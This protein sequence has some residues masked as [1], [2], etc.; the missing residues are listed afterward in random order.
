MTRYFLT[1]VNELLAAWSDR[2]HDHNT[3]PGKMTAGELGH[4]NTEGKPEARAHTFSRYNPLF[5]QSLEPGIASL[6]IALINCFD[7]VTYSSCQGHTD[8]DGKRIADLRHVGIIPRN[9]QEKRTL[10]CELT[11]LLTQVHAGWA[12]KTKLDLVVTQIES[13]SKSFECLDIVFDGN[14]DDPNAYFSESEALSN[15]MIAILWPDL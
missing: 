9:D 1:N 10:T 6:V 13:D 5:R 12:G 2:F 7:C 15:K 8:E 3:S 14:L 4:V 11:T